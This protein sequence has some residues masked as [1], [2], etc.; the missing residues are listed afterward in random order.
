ME[1][2]DGD[3]YPTLTLK[4]VDLSG[5]VIWEKSHQFFEMQGQGSVEEN[6]IGI[7]SASDGN[8]WITF[9]GYVGKFDASNG[10]IFSLD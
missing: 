6:L 1:M 5:N 10:E 8:L 9:E 7:A 3:E 2:L 4:E